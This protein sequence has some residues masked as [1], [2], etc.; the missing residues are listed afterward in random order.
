MQLLQV[1]KTNIYN[2]QRVS[3]KLVDKLSSDIQYAVK[4]KVVNEKFLLV[5]RAKNLINSCYNLNHL[6]INQLTGHVVK[7]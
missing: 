3:R 4:M 1:L 6:I 7:H 2:S 5:Q